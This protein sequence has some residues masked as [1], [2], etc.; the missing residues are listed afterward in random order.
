MLSKLVFQIFLICTKH[1]KDNI[2]HQLRKNGTNAPSVQKILESLFSEDSGLVFSRNDDDFAQRED[3]LSVFFKESPYFR[4]YYEKYLAEK[5]KD[6]IQKPLR[7]RKITKLWTNNNAESV[8]KRLKQG[9]QHKILPA[10]ELIEK[11]SS[12]VQSQLINL[13]KALYGNG[14][15]KLFGKSE[16]L[17]IDENLWHEKS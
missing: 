1:L 14:N 12:V 3:N 4:Q 7:D 15:F 11:L 5:I 17:L 13:H 6:V 16:K 8:N 9:I 10:S 2:R